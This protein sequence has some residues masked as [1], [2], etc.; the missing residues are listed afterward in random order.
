MVLIESFSGVRG[1]YGVD[2]DELIAKKYATVFSNFL[3][4]KISQKICQSFKIWSSKVRKN[5][6]KQVVLDL[7]RIYPF[8]I[9]K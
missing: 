2:L 9:I 3:S 4:T 5:L 6:L 1:I 8:C 7:L